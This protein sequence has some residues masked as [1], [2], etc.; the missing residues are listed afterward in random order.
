MEQGRQGAG[1][2]E[3]VLN[4]QSPI[5]NSNACYQNDIIYFVFTDTL[6]VILRLRYS[7][8]SDFT[9]EKDQSAYG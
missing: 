5:P 3:L 6:R 1:E 7:H 9:V 2:E 4:P 8:F